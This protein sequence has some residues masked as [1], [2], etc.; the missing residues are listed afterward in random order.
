V[1]GDLGNFL[2][3]FYFSNS[4]MEGENNLFENSLNVVHYFD[5]NQ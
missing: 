4:L 1:G 2:A 3:K 5:K